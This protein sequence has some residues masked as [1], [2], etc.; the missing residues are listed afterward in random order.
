MITNVV[1]NNIVNKHD[2]RL[3][4]EALKFYVPIFHRGDEA[5]KRIEAEDLSSLSVHEV[6]FLSN[7]ALLKDIA[8]DKIASLAGPLITKEITKLINKSHLNGKDDLF[9]ILYYAGLDGMVKGLRH[10]DVDKINISSTNYIFQW[11]ITYAKK[12]LLAIEAP[13][14]IA[15]SRFAKLKKIS[16]VRKKIS[17]DQETYATNQEVLEYFKSGKANV[18][19]MN[20]KVDKNNINY[21][22]N[23]NMTLELIE[24][25]EN[26]EQ[27]LN[28]TNL[29]DPSEDYSTDITLSEE[30]HTNFAETLFGVF[31]NS[32]NFTDEACAVFMSDL[33]ISNIPVK[34]ENIIDDLKNTDY[35]RLSSLWKNLLRDINGPFYDFLKTIDSDSIF[36]EFDVRSVMKNI[37]NYQGRISKKYLVLF[38]DEK[39]IKL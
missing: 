22:S 25:Q 20:G 8:I 31:L 7:Q 32:Y 29:L 27:N 11:I 5:S 30:I 14:G 10:F 13:F 18:K 39:V 36:E 19:N 37:E 33:K 12:E 34:Y 38:V 2:D 16:A 1:K 17:E 35:R 3:T 26:F 24:E 23:Q 4:I 15:P 6:N 21:L 28:N 9:D